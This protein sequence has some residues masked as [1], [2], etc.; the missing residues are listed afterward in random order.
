MRD[1]G[2]TLHEI[3]LGLSTMILHVFP[4]D[5]IYG[6][7]NV[8]INSRKEKNG[9]AIQSFEFIHYNFNRKI[10][11]VLKPRAHIQNTFF[12]CLNEVYIS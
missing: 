3:R 1:V 5:A 12:G 9:V 6:F 10:S 8:S 2:S 11:I 4:Y 7:F